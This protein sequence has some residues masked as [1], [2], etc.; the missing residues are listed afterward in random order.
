MAESVT[1]DTSS[2]TPISQTVTIDG[3]TFIDSHPYAGP[4]DPEVV[5]Q[6]R[7][8][9]HRI[10]TFGLPAEGIHV[11]LEVDSS[12]RIVHEA[13]A[14]PNHLAQRAFSYPR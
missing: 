10:L 3:P 2:A 13:L 9:G 7:T 12:Y 6:T 1:S 4:P 11:E 5:I 8:G 14:V